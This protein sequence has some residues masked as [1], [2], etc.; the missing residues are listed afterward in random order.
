MLEF[1]YHPT[2]NPRKVALFLE[3]SGLDYTLMPLDISRGEQHAPEYR[4]INPNG[5]VPAIV[6]DGKA[7]FDSAAIMIHLADRLG[8]FLGAPDGSQRAE[9]MSWVMLVSSGLGPFTGQAIHFSHYAPQPQFY[10][11]RRYAYEAHRHWKLFDERLA[12]QRYLVDGHYTIADMSLW[13]WCRGLVYLEGEAIWEQ[14]PNVKRL[15]SEI[16]ARPAAQ[17]ANALAHRH[18]FKHVRDAETYNSLF[19]Y[20]LTAQP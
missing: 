16:E 6:E 20:G 11:L 14:Y 18:D 3:E 5:K 4:A 13:G 12:N 19:P 1:Y 2:P 15:Y 10:G 9:V 8:R 7:I 17:R